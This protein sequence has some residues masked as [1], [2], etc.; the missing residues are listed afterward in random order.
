MAAPILRVEGLSVGYRTAGRTLHALRDVSLAIEPGQAYGLVGESGSGKS[1]LALAIMG[2]LPPNARVLGGSVQFASR[3]L[4]GLPQEDLR[5][6]WGRQLA[7]VPQNPATALNPSMRVG[8]QLA[9]ALR[10][11]GESGRLQSRAEELLSQVRV[12]DPARVARQYPHQLSGGMQQRVL[13]ALALSGH[14]KLLIL[15]E[16]TTA[17]DVTTE[18]AILDLLREAAAMLG[19]AML[20]VTHNLGVVATFSDRVAVLYAGE[21]AED[22]PTKPLFRKPLHPYTRGLLDSVPRLGQRKD[23]SPL[24]GL[25]GQLPALDQIPNACIYAPRCPLAI[26][27]CWQQRPPLDA[28]AADH[29]VRCHRWPEILAGEI[30]ASAVAES[31]IPSNVGAGSSH[32]APNPS[33]VGAGSPRPQVLKVENLQ[34]EYPLPRPLLSLRGALRT[35]VRRADEAISHAQ[36]NPTLDSHSV[37]AV[38]DV[39]L[40]TGRGRT[41]GIV[42]ESGSGKSSLSRAVVGLVHPQ[43]GRVELLGLHLPADVDERTRTQL[44]QLQMI[45]QNPEEALNP[46]L[47]VGES[48]SRP[49][50]TLA[51]IPAR[52][53]RQR[54]PELLQAVRLPAEYASRLPGQLSGGEKQRV[55]I[56]RAFA[57]SPQLL[58]ADEPVSA[59]DVS[60][61]A[62]ILNLLAELQDQHNTS[63]LFIAHDIAV[64]GYLADEIAVMY[65]GQLMQVSPAAAIFDAPYHPYTEALLSSVPPPDPFVEQERIRLEGELPSAIHP[66][67]G[68]PFHTRCPRFLGDICVT[69]TPPW[70]ETADGTRIFCHIPVDELDRVQKPVLNFGQGGA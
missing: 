65:L 5:S 10:I 2:Y 45:F 37:K 53:A 55:A 62:T 52:E 28:P 9:E 29:G 41:L 70:Q 33:G 17:L 50:I 59:L 51:G 3:E 38:R 48:L 19:T 66:P 36:P 22:A 31:P 1:T 64:V 69:Q 18:A 6:L 35:S 43:A 47:T 12:A 13:I 60:V 14:P 15:D 39:S 63:M 58:I 56:A 23:L 42:G 34:V 8:D 68:C 49:L 32:P 4:L 46:Y 30:S 27:I 16:P 21:L 44:A 67:T 25:P 61:Q 20:Y 11:Y 24:R 54:V 57:A 40:Q 7:F 26:Q